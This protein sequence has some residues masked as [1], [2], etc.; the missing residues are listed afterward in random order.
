M[1]LWFINN[2]FVEKEEIEGAF[3]YFVVIDKDHHLY[4][5]KENYELIKSKRK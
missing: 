5:N 1:K 3:E 4:I 2:L